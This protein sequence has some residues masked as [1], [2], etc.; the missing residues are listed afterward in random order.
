MAGVAQLVELWIVIPMPPSNISDLT[1]KIMHTNAYKWL[2]CIRNADKS[3]HWIYHPVLTLP[4]VIPKRVAT[5]LIMGFKK[6]RF[7][8]NLYFGLFT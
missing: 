8:T 3:E 4:S 5:I 1:P 2:E 6:I 7:K